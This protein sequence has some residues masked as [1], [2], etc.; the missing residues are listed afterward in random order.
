MCASMPSGFAAHV[1]L[2]SR[3]CMPT[4]CLAAR[5]HCSQPRASQAAQCEGSA[6]KLCGARA[7]AVAQGTMCRTLT[8][9]TLRGMSWDGVLLLAHG[10][11]PTPLPSS[12]SEKVSSR[13]R[14]EPGFGGPPLKF[15]LPKICRPFST[16]RGEDSIQQGWIETPSYRASY[17]MG[18]A[19]PTG[20]SQ[21]CSSSFARVSTRGS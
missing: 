5:L 2:A 14:V 8:N 9:R 17:G 18:L 6:L 20:M 10:R 21:K 11:G 19:G 3:W 4:P 12:M 13:L 1:L 16:I 7:R 15:G